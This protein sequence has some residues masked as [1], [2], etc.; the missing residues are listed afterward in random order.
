MKS[1]LSHLISSK[2]KLA[3][4]YK[5]LLYKAN[6]CPIVLYSSSIWPGAA[7]THLGR[8]YTFQNI[9][10][11]RAANAPWL[12]PQIPNKS[13]WKIPAY[14]NSMSSSSKRSR[15]VLSNSY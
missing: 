10:L 12:L 15:A 7:V 6:F 14:D 8:L 2:S 3:F 5:I 13:A 1:A 4:K 9:Q 11:R